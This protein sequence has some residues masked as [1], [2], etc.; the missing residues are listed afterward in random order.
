MGDDERD[1]HLHLVDDVEGIFVARVRED[2]AIQRV[3][4][5]IGCCLALESIRK[6]GV[7]LRD[8]RD[9]AAKHH[10][11]GD[12]DEDEGQNFDDADAV[13]EPV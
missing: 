12:G 8:P 2:D 4:Q 3:G 7:G 11:A 13:G 1:A 5:A 10:Q 9:V 6:V